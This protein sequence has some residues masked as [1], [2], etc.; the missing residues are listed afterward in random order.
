MLPGKYCVSSFQQRTWIC[1]LLLEMNQMSPK[2]LWRTSLKLLMNTF[3]DIG[4]KLDA[5]IQVKTYFISFLKG[6]NPN[7]MALFLP[8][9]VEIY[10]AIHSLNN[11]KSSGVDIIPSYFLKVASSVIT[12]HL[13]HLF[14]VCGKNGLFPEVL[15]VSKAFP[16]GLFHY[17]S[18]KNLSIFILNLWKIVS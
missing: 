12:P 14:N 2:M 6:R 3:W 17:I 10:N 15:K 9:F 5:K 4:E 8:T 11:K 7:S 16:I 13:M 1:Q 18:K